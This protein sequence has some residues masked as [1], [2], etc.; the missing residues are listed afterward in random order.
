MTEPVSA[1]YRRGISC[2]RLDF[3]L[4]VPP[5]MPSVSPGR[6]LKVTSFRTGWPEPCL[7]L[8][9]TCS[10]SMPPSLTCCTGALGAGRSVV[11]SSTSTI[12]R[13]EAAD[14]AIITKAVLSIIRA[15]RMFIM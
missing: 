13:A 2:T 7:Y 6:M 11:S 1:S 10:N 9:V 8:K 5:M 15:I 12:R 4:P 14:M 3:A